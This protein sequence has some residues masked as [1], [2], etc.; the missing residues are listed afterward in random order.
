M[1][2]TTNHERIGAPTTNSSPPTV[3]QRPS[4]TA[5][6]A[7]A[8]VTL[9]LCLA[10]SFAM[11]AVVAPQGPQGATGQTG[12]QGAAGAQGDRG[13][14]GLRGKRGRPG[15]IG[16]AGAAGAA[17]TNTVTERACSNDLSVPLPFCS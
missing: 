5:M 8:L 9:A 7:I 4:L 3:I 17:G 11:A 2:E 16:A 1:T 14:R 13:L 6:L 12:A 15:K 10:G